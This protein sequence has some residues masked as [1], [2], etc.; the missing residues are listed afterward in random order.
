[1]KNSA[2]E[3]TSKRASRGGSE[4]HRRKGAGQNKRVKATEC[5]SRGGSEQLRVLEEGVSEW[6]GR[7]GTKTECQQTRE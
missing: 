3:G 1:M 6:V 5:A 7:G 4:R 2:G